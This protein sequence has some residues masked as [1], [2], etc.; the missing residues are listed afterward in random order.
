MIKERIGVASEVDAYCTKCRLV[1]N[2]RVVAMQAGVIKR[3]ICLTC[4][5]QHNFRPPPGEKVR[6]DSGKRVVRGHKPTSKAKDVFPEWTSL[7]EALA[8]EKGPVPYNMTQSFEKGQAIEHAH[9]GL[10]FVSK[11][12][13][14]RKMV[15]MFAKEIKTLA[16]NHEV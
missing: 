13:G 8:P 3:V 16:M 7:K 4:D 14:P 12:L 5:G 9:F 2:H 10:G 1:T 15:V 11:I 6:S